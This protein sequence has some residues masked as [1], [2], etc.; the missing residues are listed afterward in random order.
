MW[1]SA[2]IRLGRVGGIAVDIH[3]TFALVLGWAAWQGWVHYRSLA[4]AGYSVLSIGLLFTCV[5]LHELGHA[6]QARAVN[7]PVRNLILLPIGGLVQLESNPSL[8]WHEVMVALTGPMVNLVLALVFGLFAY[9]LQPFSPRGWGDYVLFRATP[10]FHSL[11]LYLLWANLL[12]FFFNMLPAFP[13]DGGRVV[14]GA[15]AVLTDY[16]TATRVMAWLG[17]IVAALLVFLGVVGWPP[18]HI[19]A[20]PLLVV[21]AIAV[22][23]GARQEVLYVRRQRALVRLEV[24]DVIHPP[25]EVLAPWDPVTHTLARQ[26]RGDRALPVLVGSRLVGLVAGSDV[27]RLLHT[28]TEP[29]TVA[30]AMRAD[31]P[32]LQPRDTLWVALQEMTTAQMTVLPV[33]QEG[34]FA[35]VISM[36]DIQNAW[37][38][39]ARRRTNTTFASG[40]VLE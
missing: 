23:I 27:R 30:H 16:E 17:G 11:L 39:S 9:L 26:L 1:S 21:V 37:R 29:L 14:R 13:M 6:L 36:Q 35:G 3:P 34:V 24:G 40:D 5:L 32:V 20:N 15:L 2:G 28:H 4:G 18:A 8:P 31:F 19:D 38:Y 25:A 12:L 22:A 10:G 7:L 33:V